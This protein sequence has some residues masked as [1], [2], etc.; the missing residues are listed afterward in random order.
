MN[1]FETHSKPTAIA[2]EVFDCENRKHWSGPFPNAETAYE[3]VRNLGPM[4]PDR[5]FRV[6]EV[7]VKRP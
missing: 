5:K 6:N 1:L 4:Y 3:I 2:F 7:R